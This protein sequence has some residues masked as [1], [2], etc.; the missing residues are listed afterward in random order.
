M[1]DQQDYIRDIA[2]VRAMMERSSRFMSLSGLS[3]IM[4]GIYALA[5]AF[6][7]YYY[8]GYRPGIYSPP[9]HSPGMLPII[10]LALGVLVLTLA[11]AIILSGRKARKRGERAWN[12]TARRMLLHM[13]VP[14]LA[15]GLLILILLAQ[16][17]GSL[18]APLTLIFY[19]LALFN[20]GKLT[21]KEINSLGLLEI[22]LG[23]ISAYFTE[24]AL[25]CWALGFGAA[26]IVYGMYVHY[27]YER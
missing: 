25:I 26:H 9:A 5:G 15:G 21:F 13:A 27:R 2:E 24:Y 4:A 6:I 22:C 7:A 14:L 19:G 11:T 1:K 18:V 8:L 10:V 12:P 20:A 16:G 3:G 23:L 17:L